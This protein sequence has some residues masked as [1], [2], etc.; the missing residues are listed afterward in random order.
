[1]ILH[2]DNLFNLLIYISAAVYQIQEE[3]VPIILVNSYLNKFVEFSRT[4]ILRE[5]MTRSTI[6]KVKCIFK[7]GIMSPFSLIMG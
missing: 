1:M 4:R 2:I 3:R 7:L 6:I 5:K